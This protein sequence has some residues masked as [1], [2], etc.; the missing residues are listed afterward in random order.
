[1]KQELTFLQVVT[2]S[3]II[4]IVIGVGIGMALQQ[5]LMIKTINSVGENLEGMIT[6]INIEI[7]LNETDL[8]EA[9]YNMFPGARPKNVS[10]FDRGG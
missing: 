6:E 3:L 2:I 10:G 1:M 9:T 4:G 7:E 8:V 5:F